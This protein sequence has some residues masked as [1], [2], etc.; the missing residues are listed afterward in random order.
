MSKKLIVLGALL[1]FATLSFGQKQ[2]EG[3]RSPLAVGPS[4]I[5][6]AATYTS[7]S[8]HNTTTYC[9]T[10]NGNIPQFSRGGEEMIF[11]GEVLEGYGIC[12]FNSGI[13]YYDYA[14]FDSGNWNPSTLTFPSA[15]TAVSTRITSDGIWQLTQ[16]ITKVSASGTDAGQAKVKMVIRNLTGVARSIFILR[17]ADVDANS[18]T[19]PNDFDFTVDTAFG[20]DPGFGGGLASINNTFSFPYDAYTQNTFTPPAPCSAFANIATQPF[21]GDGSIV[22]LWS[23]KVPANSAKTVQST[24]RPI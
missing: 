19:T 16:T 6:C 5:S 14:A 2:G 13:Q 24:Y 9:V 3:A 21:V 4:T 7:G 10:V 20:L 15:T 1:T 11:V 17:Y 23:I 8:G 12:D 22:Q 18:V